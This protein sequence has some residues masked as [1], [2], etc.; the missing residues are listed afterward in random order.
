M[1]YLLDTNILLRACDRASSSYTLALEAIAR[2]LAQDEE[3]VIIPRLVL[4]EFWVVAT[5]PIAVNGLGWNA[6]QTHTEVEQ[7]LD[8][9]TLLEDNLQIF[10]H[11]LNYVT[12]YKVMGKRVHDAR[13][14]GV[15]LT[16]GVT[17]LLT[18]NIDDFTNTAGIVVVHPQ[19]VIDSP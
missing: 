12:S 3:C 14:I 5:R 10:T 18:F 9:F 8:Q 17:H 1:R 6:E 7:I 11:W 19:T 4:I 16:H 13:L 2:L 15:M